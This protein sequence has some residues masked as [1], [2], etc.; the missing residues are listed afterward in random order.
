MA[1]NRAIEENLIKMVSK[2][3]TQGDQSGTPVEFSIPSMKKFLVC[4]EQLRNR[5]KSMISDG[6]QEKLLNKGRKL[7]GPLIK[8]F[9]TRSESV[10]F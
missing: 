6:F 8:A 2:L 7:Y 1:A 3:V 10:Q 4:Y 5:E 9:A